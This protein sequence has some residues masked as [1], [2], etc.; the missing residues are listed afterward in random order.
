[1]MRAIRLGRGRH[2]LP[3]AFGIVSMACLVGYLVSLTAG[4][5]AM[6]AQAYGVAKTPIVN[7]HLQRVDRDYVLFAGDS[8]VELYNPPPTTCGRATVNAAIGGLGVK[9][10]SEFLAGLSFPRKPSAVMVTVGT[11]DLFRKKAP[12][13]ARTRDQWEADA[14]ALLARL[15]ELAPV[16]VVNALPP[17]GEPLANVLDPDAVKLYSDILSRACGEIRG[18]VFRDSFVGI[19]SQRFGIA[20]AGTMA[21][22]LHVRD[23]RRAYSLVD[24]DICRG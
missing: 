3:I 18:C 19:R 13:S 12:T 20:R 24:A 15:R 14:K 17:F 11:N 10:Y 23:Y 16:L 9:P 5:Q 7:G 6:N 8:H 2:L 1:M 22:E 21:D 4:A